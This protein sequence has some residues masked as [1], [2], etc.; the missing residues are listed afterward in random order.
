MEEQAKKA[1]ELLKLLGNENRLL[2]LCAL[3]DGPR[4]VS[5][6]HS[7]IPRITQSALSQHLT[8][9]KASGVLESERA[10]MNTE[11]HIA[12]NRVVA[13]MGSLKE[14]FCGE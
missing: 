10:G 6:I 5:H 9:L 11:Y 14:H 13:L 8:L 2:I 7:R 1:A 12:D 3:I 4:T